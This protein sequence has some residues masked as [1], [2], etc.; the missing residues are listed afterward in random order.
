MELS[1]KYGFDSDVN[2]IMF[3]GVRTPRKRV[4]LTLK[5][6][7]HALPELDNW[8]L[9]F[10]GGVSSHFESYDRELKQLVDD[11]GIREQ[12][13]MTGFVESRDIPAM[14]E[15]ADILIQTPKL[16]PS[17]SGPISLGIGYHL[18][19]ILTNVDIYQERLDHRE[20]AYF[21]EPTPKS[22]GEGIQ[23]LATDTKLREKLAAGT[24]TV[25]EQYSWKNTAKQTRAIYDSLR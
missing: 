18:P 24:E 19:M 6:F 5:G 14:L 13:T 1:E 23:T 17:A 15:V 2:H 10:A 3:F 8:E 20:S 7:A 25:A 9:V 21:V 12:I 4:D 16:R 22:I 11:L